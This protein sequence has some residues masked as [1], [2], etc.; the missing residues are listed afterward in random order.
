MKLAAKMVL[1]VT[2]FVTLSCASKKGPSEIRSKSDT[3]AGNHGDLAA[4]NRRLAWFTG[5]ETVSY[6]IQTG[7]D[8]TVPAATLVKLFDN[9][10]AVWASSQIVRDANQVLTKNAAAIL[11]TKAKYLTN[12]AGANLVVGFGSRF[13][14]QP[15]NDKILDS[16]EST[17]SGGYYLQDDRYLMW[18]AGTTE[19]PIATGTIPENRIRALNYSD[20]DEISA[21]LRY[22]IG[23]MLG[24][25]RTPGTL[26]DQLPENLIMCARDKKAENHAQCESQLRSGA[27]ANPYSLITRTA[28]AATPINGCMAGAGIVSLQVD[29]D[30][31]AVVLFSKDQDRL[32]LQWNDTP[33]V[34]SIQEIESFA[35]DD[36]SRF[37]FK[38][39][40][41]SGRIFR[42]PQDDYY[43]RAY[44]NTTEPET[45]V[46]Y[47]GRITVHCTDGDHVI[48][49]SSE[50]CSAPKTQTI[51]QAL[52]AILNSCR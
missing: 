16:R 37:F 51:Q 1:I 22:T 15:F 11:P 14:Q 34:A 4:R 7:D 17:I 42:N 49:Q 32:I 28:T 26:M 5:N 29:P 46:D 35:T 52:T 33:T 47:A 48:F 36:T 44:I 43:I 20:L 19:A 38:Q 45:K 39:M 2:S 9:A 13:R 23:R 10:F 12:C 18:T 25:I 40:I 6:C 31:Q 30:T 41:V 8:V 24:N 50:T 27:L 21:T 3:G